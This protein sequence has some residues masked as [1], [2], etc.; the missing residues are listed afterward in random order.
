V[1]A[2]GIKTTPLSGQPDLF[3]GTNATADAFL[4]AGVE[5]IYA[6]FLRLVSTS[7]KLPLDKVGEIA[8]GRVWDGGTARQLGLVDAFGSLDDAVAEAARM[9]KISPDSVSR[10][11]LKP[12]KSFLA[13]LFEDDFETSPSGHVDIFTQMARRQQALALRGLSDAKAMLDGPAIQV[14]CLECPSSLQ[15]KAAHS[16]QDLT[17]IDRIV[18]WLI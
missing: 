4:Q 16:P 15:L 5:D 9:A 14:R 17:L 8:Q 7:R 1:T 13:S 2:D 6:R 12:E 3:A 11:Y 10:V 18:S